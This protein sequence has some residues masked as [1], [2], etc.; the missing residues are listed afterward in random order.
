MANRPKPT[1]LKL[2][3]GNPGRRPIN[4]REPLPARKKPPRPAHLSDKAR[5]AWPKV[6]RILSG[7]SV[8]TVADGLALEGLCE[9]YADYQSSRE[10]IKAAGG[11]YYQV[12]MGEGGGVMWRAH[13]AVASRNDA[14]RRLRAWLVEFGLTPAARSKVKIDGKPEESEPAERFFAQ[15]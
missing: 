14:D 6:A 8:L 9:A 12:Q 2:V 4:G 7:V 1:V 3:Q 11:E 15:A 10:A 13:P 5:K